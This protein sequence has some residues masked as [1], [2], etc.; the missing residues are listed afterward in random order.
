MDAQTIHLML[1]VTARI[2]F[3][4]FFC[5]FTAPALLTMCPAPSTRWLAE[6]RR[7]WVLAFAASHTVHLAFIIALAMKPGSMGSVR[8]FGWVTLVGGGTV[9]LFI[10]ALA[11]A[12]AFPAKAGCV[13]SPRFLSFAYYPIWFVFA[14]SYVAGAVRSAFFLPFAVAAITALLL[15]LLAARQTRRAPALSMVSR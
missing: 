15:R 7:R 8:Q 4:F 3:L 10:Y 6:R 11:A 2:T 14:S 13:L 12:V 5:A 9:Y 1:R